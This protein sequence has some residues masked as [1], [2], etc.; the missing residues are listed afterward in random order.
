MARGTRDTKIEVIECQFESLTDL[1][2]VV[3]GIVFL[4]YQNSHV[5][6]QS[7]LV[8]AREDTTFA[9]CFRVMNDRKTKLKR[10]AT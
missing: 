6:I 4:S 2:S 8:F 5:L 7:G 3:Q 9:Y 1:F 10:I